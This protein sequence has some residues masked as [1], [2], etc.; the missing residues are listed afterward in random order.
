MARF[1]VQVRPSLVGGAFPCS[2]GGTHRREVWRLSPPPLQ[3]GGNYLYLTRNSPEFAIRY[4]LWRD[5]YRGMYT[6]HLIFNNSNTCVRSN[7]F[8]M[9]QR[10]VIENKNKKHA[11]GLVLLVGIDRGRT[12]HPVASLACPTLPIQ[13]LILPQISCHEL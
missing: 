8:D 12:G 6:L 13:S 4:G 3:G 2:P 7:L 5:S 1:A 11:S 10:L 9:I